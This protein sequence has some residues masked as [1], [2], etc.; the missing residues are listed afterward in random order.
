MN[1]VRT[2]G[3]VGQKLRW[4]PEQELFPDNEAANRL[5]SRK[6]RKGYELPEVG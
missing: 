3:Q 6:R 4:D 1:I 2:L 5:L